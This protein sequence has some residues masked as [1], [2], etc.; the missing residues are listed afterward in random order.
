ML[1]VGHRGAAGLVSENTIGSFKKA[2][3]LGVD[4]IELDLRQSKTGQ[5]IAS[6]NRYRDYG[7]APK[8]SEILAVIKTPLNLELKETGFEVEVLSVIK[9]FSS[10]VLISSKYPM[11]LQKIRALD[12]N[13]QLG[14][15]LGRA[16]FFLLPWIARLDRKLKLYSVHLKL[17]LTFP[18]VVNYLKFLGKQVIAW[19]VNDSQSLERLKTLNI[20]G[21][22]TDYP[23]LIR[24]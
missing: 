11:V 2:E 6:H 22:I 4:M 14:L 20:D 17:F 7:Q 21:V 23:N 8:L 10:S 19:T 18:I 12:E 1:I 3:E 15:V 13:I 16:N 24:K 5:I 9:N